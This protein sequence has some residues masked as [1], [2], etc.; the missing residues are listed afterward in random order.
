[1]E[2]IIKNEV[3]LIAVY[4]RVSTSLQEEQE[5]IQAQLLQVRNFAKEHEYIIVKE[6]CDDGWSG[7]VLARPAL[8]E[9]RIDAK[10]RPWEAVLIYDPDRLGR[11]YFYQELII[12]ELSQL[13]IQTLFVTVPP[14]ENMNDKMLAGF[15]GLFAEYERAKISERFRIGKINRINS[16][17]VLTTEAP[18]G[19]TYIKNAGK[20]GTK[21]YVAGY[22]KIDEKEA[23]VVKMI[24]KWVADEGLTLRAVVRRLQE[25]TIFPRKSKRNVWSTSTL[26]T[27]LR[28][29]VYIGKAHWSASYAVFPENPL[30]KVKYKK[31][32]SRRMRPEKEW[33]IIKVPSIIE[34]DIFDRAGKRLRDNFA[35][36]GR[37]KKNDYL[38]AGKIWCTCGRR[39][40]GEGPQHGK[41]LYYR[42][43]DRVYSFPLPRTCEE[44]GINAKIADDFVWQKIKQIMS[45]PELMLSQI[46]RWMK[47]HE[48]DK[49]QE[50]LQESLLDIDYTKKEIAKLK[51]QED[52]FATAYSKDIIDLNQ[53]RNYVAPLKEQVNILEKKLEQTYSKQRNKLE[54]TTPT[55]E[56]IEY[57]AKE[58]KIVLNG[59]KFN[60]RKAI[61]NKTIE[62]IIST[63]KNLQVYGLINLQEIYVGFITK[64]RYCRPA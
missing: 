19:Y 52:K 38:L 13:G 53:L 25:H 48:G 32:T 6:Y 15:R 56:A 63:Q 5:T 35:L 46:K 41:Y 42:C 4:A 60:S 20:R 17:F 36:M 61:V 59:L 29:Q 55:D 43:T 16:G 40:A 50:S 54:I 30:K 33:M 34:Q 10:K 24:F 47:E 11:K 3:K 1:M 28:S 51:S 26:S 22:Y 45:N 14:I 8:D 18:Y 23:R 39:R 57:F 27:L 31:K 58:A 49:K 37:N 9:L 64:N 12:D 7:D 21:E 44:K 2:H 62:K